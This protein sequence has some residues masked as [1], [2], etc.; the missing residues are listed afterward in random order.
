LEVTK[1]IWNQGA[2]DKIEAYTRTW[3]LLLGAGVREVP[4][5]KRS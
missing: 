2:A 3:R 4:D 1:E 5:K